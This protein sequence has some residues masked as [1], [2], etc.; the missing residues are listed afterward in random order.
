MSAAQ[1]QQLYELR[2]KARLV[3]GKKTEES[4]QNSE[5]R[6]AV[7][8]EKTDNISNQCI[9]AVKNQKTVTERTQIKTEKGIVPDRTNQVVECLNYQRE[10]SSTIT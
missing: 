5:T 7:L 10:A 8:E 4:A 3:K 1:K 9:F 6:V 2:H